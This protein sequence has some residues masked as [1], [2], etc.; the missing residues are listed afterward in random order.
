VR[1]AI[2][3]ASFLG[4]AACGESLSAVEAP[5]VSSDPAPGAPTRPR[6]A[7]AAYADAGVLVSAGADGPLR[8]G[9]RLKGHYWCAQGRTELTLVIEDLQGDA[10]AAIFEF[11]YPGSPANAGAEGSFRMRGTFDVR[12]GALELKADRWIDRPDGYVAVDLVGKLSQRGSVTGRVIGPGCSTFAL[13]G[14]QS[15]S[16]SRSPAVAQ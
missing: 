5:M 6:A 7:S 2:A 8:R 14:A 3:L 15:Q 13:T 11:D 10:V 9:D 16:R 12:T 1:A 4:A